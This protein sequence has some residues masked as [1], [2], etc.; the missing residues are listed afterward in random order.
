RARYLGLL[1]ANPLVWGVAC[2]VEMVSPSDTPAGDWIWF[3][4]AG[5]AASG[6]IALAFDH[7]V[8]QFYAAL[9]VMPPM[10]VMLL[11]PHGDRGF[12]LVSAAL[13][14][15]YVRRSS[16]VVHDDY[17]TAA[18][19]RGELEQRALELERMSCTD[20]LTQVANRLHF[21]RRLDQEWARARRN[22]APLALMMVDVDHFK[23]V[24]D[25]FGHAF[26]DVCLQAV[27]TALRG[28]L[29]RPGDLLAR[30]GGE[31][32]VVMLPGTGI[33]GAEVVAARL[34]AAVANLALS[35]GADAVP[36]TCSVGLHVAAAPGS[37]SAA[38]ALSRADQA[39]YL[40]KH[41]GRNRV[42]RLSE[43]A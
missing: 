31:E 21:D 13:F 9:A 41:Q 4:L 38:A 22:A 14:L 33:D 7:V 34:H 25:A 6:G 1:L 19:A 36:V 26:G 10:L 5:V 15:M 32:F 8:R 2:A 42:V 3:T 16:G 23:K 30:Y 27:A 40:A 35:H 11:I 18:V 29:T 37:A 12:H 43:T 17:W 20:T 24:N 28:A 39:L